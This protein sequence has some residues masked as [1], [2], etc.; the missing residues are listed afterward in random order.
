MKKLILFL[1]IPFAITLVTS[2]SDDDPITQTPTGSI[3][4]TSIPSDA[5]IWIDGSN[6]FKTTPDTILDV[7]EG[8]RSV[9]LKL[10]DYR[11]TTFSISV[12]GGETSLVTNVGLVSDISTELYGP[13]RIYEIYNTPASQP[14]GLDLSNGMAYGVSSREADLIDIYFYSDAGG[15]S[16]LIQSAD[17][18]P[19]LIRE[20]DFLVSSGTNLFDAVDSPLRNT[21]TWTDNIDDTENNYVFLYDHD[22]HYS[23]M[24]LVNRGGGGGPG[25]PSWVDIQWY[26]NNTNLD[27]RF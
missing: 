3:Y 21:G 16:Y 2:C 17:L 25:D 10:Q 23:K 6:T 22:G 14:S 4:L 26:Y 15:N 24:K 5:E 18:Y 7:D 11:D 13:I 12:T 20:T 19:S 27:N 1:L 8:V 9:T